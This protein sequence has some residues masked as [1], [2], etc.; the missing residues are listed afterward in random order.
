MVARIRRRQR[1]M[2]LGGSIG[3][4]L[5]AVVAVILFSNNGVE[6]FLVMFVA[7]VGTAFGGAWAIISYQPSA[8]LARPLV[9]RIRS[10]QLSDYLTK[11]ERFGFWI[12]PTV[13]VVGAAAGTIIFSQI[14]EETFTHQSVI[15]GIVAVLALVTW[16][17]SL[18]ALRKVLAAPARNESELEFAWDNA[19]RADSLRQVVNLG[20]VVASTSLFCWLM[21]IGL[22]VTTEGFYRQFPDLT[23]VITLLSLLIYGGL[24]LVAAAGPLRAW[25]NGSCRGYE[26]RQLWAGVRS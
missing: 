6:G 7:A 14:S 2:A 16:G 12:I 18:Y 25:A 1:G 11:G 13:L 26:Q 22:A 23:P 9:A 17:V 4:V 10:V 8:E 21:D 5:A 3:I 24:F 19:E 20:V 15:A